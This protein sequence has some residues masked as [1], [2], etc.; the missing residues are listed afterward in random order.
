MFIQVIAGKVMDADLL[1]RQAQRWQE[2]IRPGAVG[3][4]GYTGGITPDGR[5]ISLVRFES[6]EA[7]AANSERAEQSSWWNEM[8]KAFDGEPTFHDCHEVD[9]IFGGGSDDAGFVQV[10]DGRAKDQAAMRS[11]VGEMETS[12]RQERPDILGITMAWHGDGGGFTQAAYF[13]SEEEAR[14]MEQATAQDDM[15][16][17]YADMFDGEPVFYDVPEPML[18]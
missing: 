4:L 8:A 9:M 2:E 14:R 7:A 16:R 13:R 18:F 1:R 11:Q 6:A 17:E 5:T 15:T 10:I 12:L 3:Y